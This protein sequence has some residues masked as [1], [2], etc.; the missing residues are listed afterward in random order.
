MLKGFFQIEHEN[1]WNPDVP[2]LR[3]KSARNVMVE[4]G[5]DYVLNNGPPFNCKKRRTYNGIYIFFLLLF[6]FFF[7][8]LARICEILSCF[9]EKF[10][11]KI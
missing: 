7:A 1:K 4:K 2:Y 11:M 3:E 10:G 5:P 9:G 6:F 8:F